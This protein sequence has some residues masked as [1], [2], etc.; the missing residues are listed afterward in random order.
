MKIILT[1]AEKDILRLF[2][3]SGKTSLEGDEAKTMSKSAAKSL[4]RKGYVKGWYST[5]GVMQIA[6][7][8]AGTQHIKDN[9]N[10]DDPINWEEK[11]LKLQEAELAYQKK[12]RIWKSVSV[13]VSILL[14]VVAICGVEEIRSFFARM[15]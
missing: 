11:V 1:D 9:P 13:V 14:S 5:N 6:L 3:S 7:E 2:M 4:E 12:I 15:F 10:L 8:D